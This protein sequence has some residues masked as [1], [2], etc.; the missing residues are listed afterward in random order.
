MVDRL[1]IVKLFLALSVLFES[2]RHQRAKVDE[3]VGPKTLRRE[4]CLDGGCTSRVNA[5]EH[6]K[7]FIKG[8][9]G[10]GIGGRQVALF[11]PGCVVALECQNAAPGQGKHRCRQR[12][13]Q[14]EPSDTSLH[15]SSCYVNPGNA[16]KLP[17][18]K[19]RRPLDRLA[20]CR[21]VHGLRCA[22]RVPGVYRELAGW[23]L[24]YLRVNFPTAE[25]QDSSSE[26]LLPR[27]AEV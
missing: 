7:C 6:H 19:A 26:L 17:R 11:R 8:Y 25:S 21:W 4:G 20:R 27:L 15:M 5:T 18:N 24:N 9:K 2:L 1:T 3:D 14:N 12:N 23:A 10:W 16:Q 22:Q 13:R